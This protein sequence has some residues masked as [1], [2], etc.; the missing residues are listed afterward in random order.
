MF[1]LDDRRQDVAK[2][3]ARAEIF[4]KIL[5]VHGSIIEGGVHDGVGLMT[6]AKLSAIYEPVNHTRR[7]VGFDT[8]DGFPS[9][10]RFDGNAEVG[11]MAADSYETISSS[12]AAFNADRPVGHIAKV[13]LVKGDA[14]V[15]MPEWVKKYPHTVISLLHLD[16]DIY[17]PTLVA[18]ETFYPRMPKGAAIVFDELNMYEWPGETV[19][20]METLGIPALRLE[21]FPFT[22]TLSY[23]IL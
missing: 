12:I 10:S 21:R 13:E 9:V 1:P 5:N 4:K 23:A 20:L 22:S 18:L 2:F 8:F 3:L 11:G 14:T 6:W 16:F 15:T 19:A 7:V 17:E